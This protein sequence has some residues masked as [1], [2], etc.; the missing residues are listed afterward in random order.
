MFTLKLIP[1]KWYGVHMCPVGQSLDVS[2]SLSM[3]LYFVS[4]LIY[5]I[6][7]LGC[8]LEYFTYTTVAGIIAASYAYFLSLCS[9]IYRYTRMFIFVMELQKWMV[10]T[11]NI[12]FWRHKPGNPRMKSIWR[13]CRFT[14]VNLSLWIQIIYNGILI[15]QCH[16]ICFYHILNYALGIY[17]ILSSLRYDLLDA[18]MKNIHAYYRIILNKVLKSAHEWT[19]TWSS[20]FY[21]LLIET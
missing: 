20:V 12:E 13:K 21:S 16:I 4:L 3:C 19:G 5:S 14:K 2:H 10:S 1:T 6:G 17:L 11:I 15:A 8:V 18:F 9:Y 7:L